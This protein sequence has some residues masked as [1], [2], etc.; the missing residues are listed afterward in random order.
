VRSIPL[1]ESIV[2]VLDLRELPVEGGLWTQTWLS[3]HCSAIYYLLVAPEFSGMH[4]LKHTEI[5]FYHGGSPARMMLLHSDGRVEEPM[6]GA[7][8]VAGERPQ[9]VVPAGVWQATETLGEW[10]LLSTV[11]SPPYSSD[12]VTFGRADALCREFSHYAQR[13]RPLCRF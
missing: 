4:R 5:F 8:V 10:S 3:E 1:P 9:V 13:I 12:A 6:L 7:D 11:M 2:E